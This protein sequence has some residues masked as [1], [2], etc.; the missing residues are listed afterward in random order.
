[1]RKRLLVA[2]AALALTAGGA[3]EARE[4]RLWFTGIGNATEQDRDAA[5]NE[6]LESATEQLNAMCPGTITLVERTSTGCFQVG[7]NYSC[8]VTV[9]GQCDIHTAR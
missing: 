2:F 9:K 6:A 1:M 5:E 7:D 3:L 8:L 4:V